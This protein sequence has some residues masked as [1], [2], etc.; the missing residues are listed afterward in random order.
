MPAQKIVEACRHRS[1]FLFHSPISFLFRSPIKKEARMACELASCFS[2]RVIDIAGYQYA[3]WSFL[4]GYQ[5]PAT[6]YSPAT[7]QVQV[8]VPGTY[9][10]CTITA[11][12]T[13][14]R[15][16]VLNKSNSYPCCHSPVICKSGNPSPPLAK[17]NRALL[18][19]LQTT[20]HHHED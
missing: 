16:A 11:T 20:W 13:P 7:S 5:L 8:P 19:F 15:G 12:S 10:T 17:L 3:S 9:R 2:K 18:F 1:S 6:S 14:N 4:V